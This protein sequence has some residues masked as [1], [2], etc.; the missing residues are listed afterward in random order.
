ME[1][2][3][4]SATFTVEDGDD[5]KSIGIVFSVS[6]ALVSPGSAGDCCTSLYTSIS[7]AGFSPSALDNI[8]P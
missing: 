6:I 2:N 8:S 3:G 7:E 1:D 4:G 5:D